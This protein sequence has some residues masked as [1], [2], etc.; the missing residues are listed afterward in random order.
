MRYAKA[1]LRFVMIRTKT[2]NKKIEEKTIG[3]KPIELMIHE[4]KK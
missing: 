2:L 4:I 1:P 3:N